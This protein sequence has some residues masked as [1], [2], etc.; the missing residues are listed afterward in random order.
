MHFLA[1]SDVERLP[2]DPPGDRVAYG[3]DPLQFG[4]LRLPQV[5]TAQ[6]LYPVAIVLHGGCW[7]ASFADLGLTSPLCAAL[8][9]AGFATWNVEFRRVDSPGGGWSGTLLDVA[10]AVDHIRELAARFPLDL[11]R[12][13]MVG[14]SAGGQLALWA[15]ARHRLPTTSP[16]FIE[17]PIAARGAVNLG[18]ICDLRRYLAESPV[19]GKPILRLL[20]GSPGDVP[21]RYREVSPIEMLPL[22][23]D[24]VLI[25]GAHDTIVHPDHNRTYAT[26]AQASG[27]NVRLFVLNNAAHFEV[28]APGSPAWATVERAVVDLSGA[29]RQQNLPGGGRTRGTR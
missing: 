3:E 19:C 13:V 4:D 9:R 17:N 15:A 7:L 22:G 10:N 20:G 28:I 24:Q 29:D 5:T 26:A 12:V 2:A 18:G 6:A 25:I 14:N 11:E 23:V 27:D 1:Q 21:E 16:L 8:T